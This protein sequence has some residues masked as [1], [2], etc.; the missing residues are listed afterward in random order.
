MAQWSLQLRKEHKIESYK[1]G[2]I[3]SNVLGILVEYV[4]GVCNRTMDE[5]QRRHDL[6]IKIKSVQ[7][8]K[9]FRHQNFIF[10]KSSLLPKTH[11]TKTNDRLRT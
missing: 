5:K 3:I 7:E 8:L 11:A 4:I 9:N 6:R 1:H 10:R 2:I